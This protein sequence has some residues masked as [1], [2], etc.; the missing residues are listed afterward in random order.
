MLRA[1]IL[2]AIALVVA[3]CTGVIPEPA[4]S[5]PSGPPAHLATLPDPVPRREAKS[6]YGNPE[7]YTVWGKTYRVM[8]SAA[9]Y[10]EEGVASWYGT[11]FHGRRTSSGEPYDMYKLTAAHRSLPVPSYVRVT[12]LDNGRTTIVRVND[13]GP[14]HDERIIDLS[15][16]AAVKLRFANGGTARVLVESLERRESFYLQA[17]AFS[18]FDSADLLIQELQNKTGLTAFIVKTPA[19]SLYRVRVGPVEGRQEVQRLQSVM[20]GAQLDALVIP[21]Q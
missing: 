20:S 12:N 2:C 10:R 3:G 13:R 17:G 1:F 14:F 9:G 5:A 6:R 18:E 7:T 16:A 15:Y 21:V 11:K 19:D 8:E 4:D